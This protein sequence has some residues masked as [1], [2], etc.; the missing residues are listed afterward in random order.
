MGRPQGALNGTHLH[1]LRMLAGASRYYA[2]GNSVL[3]SL[4]SRGLVERGEMTGGM[5]R[6]YRITD[7][8]RQALATSGGRT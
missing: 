2:I 3:N 8:G 4:V 5:R 6:L 1:Y 7:A